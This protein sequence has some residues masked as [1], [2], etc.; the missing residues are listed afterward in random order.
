VY[1]WA[2]SYRGLTP[3]DRDP[4][5]KLSNGKVRDSGLWC[6]HPHT[7]LPGALSTCIFAFTLSENAFLYALLFLSKSSLRTVPIDVVSKLIRG[8]AF[9]ARTV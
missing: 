4:R 3:N 2:L 8:D 9:R 7:F 1:C 6:I 5:Q